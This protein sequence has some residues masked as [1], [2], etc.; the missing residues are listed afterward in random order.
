MKTLNVDELEQIFGKK[1]T[2][3]QR[4][5][6]EAG[7]MISARGKRRDAGEERSMKRI[8]RVFNALTD[9]KLS[10]TEGWIFMVALKL[11]REKTGS[12]LDNWIDG[13]AY[14]ALA[15]ESAEKSSTTS[16]DNLN[17]W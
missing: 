14:M 12:D 16:L 7:E 17:H 10:E 8:V 4:I 9:H 2:G 3:A 5:L 15:A 6:E 13:A 11:C 1:E